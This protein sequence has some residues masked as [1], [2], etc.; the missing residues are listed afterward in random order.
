MN[1]SRP[2]VIYWNNI[3]SPYFVGRLNALVRRGAV[4]LTA[5]F[6]QQREADRSWIVDET[7]FE[8]PYRYLNA[9]R[10]N[11]SIL[12]QLRA[13]RAQI[14]VSLYNTPRFVLGSAWANALGMRTAFRMLPTFDAWVTRSVAKELLKHCLFRWVDGVKVPGPDGVAAALRYGVPDSRIFRVTQSIDVDHFAS[15]RNFESAE[16]SRIRQ[17]LGVTGCVFLYVGRL[18]AGKGIDYLLEAYRKTAELAPDVSLLIVGDGVDEDNLRRA[19]RSLPRVIFAGFAQFEELPTYYA[20]GDVFVFPTLGDP[21]GVVVEEA[22]AAG[23][24]VIASAAAG[25]IRRR[26]EE[27]KMG[28][29][30]EERNSDL[31]SD[32]MCRLAL[33]AALRRQMGMAAHEKALRFGHDNWAADFERFAEA[34]LAMPKRRWL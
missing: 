34:L 33:D 20:A 18:W 13:E 8:F 22:M 4:E 21:N 25:D 24:P 26:V 1:R 31:L 19:A 15:A 3:P 6:E 5:W 9:S 29:V 23:L 32:R 28:Y 12:G 10:S 14:L 17:S 16:R 11:L 27:G 7:Q 30:V 2:R